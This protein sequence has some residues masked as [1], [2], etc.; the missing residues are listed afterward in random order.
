MLDFIFTAVLVL[1]AYIL[2]WA[3]GFSTGLE[4]ADDHD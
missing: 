3:Q 1:A 4:E 2:G